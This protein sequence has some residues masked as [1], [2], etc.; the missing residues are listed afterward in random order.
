MTIKKIYRIFRGNSWTRNAHE[1]QLA[2]H[3]SF[4]PGVHCVG[5]GVRLTESYKETEKMIKMHDQVTNSQWREFQPSH[6]FPKGHDNKP[7]V[8]VTYDDAM[9]YAAWLSKKTG[10]KFRLPTEEERMDAEATFVADFSNHPLKECPDVGTFGKNA[11]GVTGLLGVTYD[12]CLHVNDYSRA[13]AAWEDGS[14]AMKEAP[15]TVEQAKVEPA[16]SVTTSEPTEPTANPQESLISLSSM[17]EQRNALK[18]E[19][20]SLDKYIAAANKELA[21]I[22]LKL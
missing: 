12:W 18:A 14:P 11:D 20:A 3:G 7:V 13:V 10:R 6:T 19:L 17:I 5:V 2:F 8:N 1:V 4:D 9:E 16:V 15:S 21:R 22:G